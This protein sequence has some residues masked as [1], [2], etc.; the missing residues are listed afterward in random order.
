MIMEQQA[1]MK[2]LR[3]HYCKRIGHMKWDSL[4]LAAERSSEKEKRTGKHRAN[5]AEV[6]QRDSR[7]ESVGLM[8]KHALS[9]SVN[10]PD[11][12][13]IDSGATCHMCN[14]DMLFTEMRYLKQPQEIMLGDG[15][16]LEAIGVGVVELQSI[17]AWWKNE[18]MQ[19]T[20]CALCTTTLLQLIQC[21]TSIRNVKG[22]KL[23]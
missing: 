21:I 22:D 17:F 23:Q 3:C 13:V 19:T 5:K 12:W 16:I 8:T 11:S 18:K 6:K 1:R 7:S 14:D 20:W 9:A 10:P 2:G 4:E 15:H